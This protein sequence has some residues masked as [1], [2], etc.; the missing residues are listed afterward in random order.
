MFVTKLE[1]IE[2]TVEELAHLGLDPLETAMSW[3]SFGRLVASRRMKLKSALMDQ[4]FLAGIGNIYSDEI[5]FAAGLRWDRMSD[6]LTQEE[7]RRLYRSLTEIL[8]DAVKHRGSTLA[9]ESYVDLFGRPG[10]FQEHHQVYAREGEACRRCRRPI[11]RR[12][13]SGRSNVLLRD[14]PDLTASCAATCGA[15][16]GAGRLVPRVMPG[17]PPR[18]GRADGSATRSTGRS[19]RVRGP[20]AAVERV[21][22]WCRTGPPPRPVDAVEVSDE[23]RW[24]SG[25]SGSPDRPVGAPHVEP[26]RDGR[27]GL[28]TSPLRRMGALRVLEAVTLRGFKSFADKTVLDFEPGVSVVVGRTVRASRTSSTR[29]RGCSAPGPAHGAGSR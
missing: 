28:A 21:G 22:S 24:A 13:V 9:D 17:R 23:R 25:A 1:G 4:T 16:A 3:D 7:V 14:V 20:P 5:L 11:V 8:Q 15:G 27:G 29:W 10:G 19:G 2:D 12:K 6:S 18:P 26:I